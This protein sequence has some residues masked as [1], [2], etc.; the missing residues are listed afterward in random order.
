MY[1]HL[2]V[3][4]DGSK[5]SDKAIAHALSL[6]QAI[7]ARVTALHVTPDYPAPLYMDG[8]LLNPVPRS[9]YAKHA[10]ADAASVLDRVVKKADAAGVSCEAM[11]TIA[12]APWEAIMA[13]A[14][15]SKCDV[16]V[17]AS[18]GRRGLSALLLGSETVKVLTH[19]K[20]PVLVVR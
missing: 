18:R 8:V 20:V 12:S 7:G 19:T 6:A 1:K 3:P 4:T 11:H 13:A 5:L 9:V 16:I 17:M 15:K 14:R 2:L 10:K